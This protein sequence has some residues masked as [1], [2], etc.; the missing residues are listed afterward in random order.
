[1]RETFLVGRVTHRSTE[2]VV[3]KKMGAQ[4]P[5]PGPWNLR[6]VVRHS[7]PEEPRKSPGSVV[8]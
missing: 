6:A 7:S 2:M 5:F 4:A 1:M 8:H 3:V